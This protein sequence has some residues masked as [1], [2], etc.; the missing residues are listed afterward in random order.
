MIATSSSLSWL[1]TDLGSTYGFIHLIWVLYQRYIVLNN[2]RWRR[3]RRRGHRVRQSD[4][5]LPAYTEY[6]DSPV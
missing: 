4:D 5:E 2:M 6:A 1:L 3:R